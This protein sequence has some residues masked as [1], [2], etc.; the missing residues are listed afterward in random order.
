MKMIPQAIENKPWISFAIIL[1]VCFASAFNITIAEWKDAVD[2]SVTTAWQP[3]LVIDAWSD[4][5]RTFGLA[6]YAYWTRSGTKAAAQQ[7][8]P[9]SS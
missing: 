5:I 3:E 8:P 2:P 9:E 7:D 1:G 4:G 6:M